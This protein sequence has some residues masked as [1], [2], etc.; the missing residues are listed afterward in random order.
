MRDQA[1]DQQ[2]HAC[3]KHTTSP[4]HDQGDGHDPVHADALALADLGQ[5]S[6]GVVTLEYLVLMHR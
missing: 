2:P 5:I 4:T 1:T 3:A 6:G